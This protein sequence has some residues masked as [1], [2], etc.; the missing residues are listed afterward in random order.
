MNLSSI[1]LNLLYALDI[2]LSTQNVSKAAKKL[3]LSQPQVSNMLKELRCI[4]D[5]ELL[6]RGPRNKML[7]TEKGIHLISPV[8]EAITKCRNIF[9]DEIPFDSKVANVNFKIG[10]NDYGSS[11]LIPELTKK[12]L[13]EA[14]NISISVKNIN[15]VDDYN[16]LFS[17]NLD[18]IIGFFEKK[19]NSINF[20]KLFLS[21][22][23]CVVSK[24]HPVINRQKLLIEDFQKY[25]FIQIQ[26]GYKF[27]EKEVFTIIDREIKGK[28]KILT[29]VPHALTALSILDDTNFMC[30][31]HKALAEK[32]SNKFNITTIE[33]PFKLRTPV[34][35]MYWKKVD[36][37]NKEN[38]WLRNTI[39]EVTKKVNSYK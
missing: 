37:L 22:L 14:P 30:I 28:R 24:D 13:K 18:L 26:F 34:Y 21:E 6:S 27:W 29:T 3:R 1:N 10:L 38:L 32:Y 12:L 39:K 25:P 8:R 17:D 4:F 9:T 23:T 15:N 7:L 36:N 2:L 16:T 35:S 31:T 19:S 20:E 33:L 11:L 5:D